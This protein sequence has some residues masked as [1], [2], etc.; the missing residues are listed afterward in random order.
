M[1]E[2]LSPQV[3]TVLYVTLMILLAVTLPW[4]VVGFWNALIGLLLCQLS[5]EP[6]AAVL[7]REMDIS[8]TEPLTSST[9]VLLC[10][11]NETP[12]RI[13]RNLETM[14]Q[15]LAQPGIGEHFHLYILSDTSDRV[16]GAQ[17]QSCFEAM[18]QRWSSRIAITYRCRTDN[19]GYKAGNIAD[20]CKHWGNQH[21]FALTLDVDSFM[22]SGSMLRLVR[23]MQASPR[24]GILQ[25]L[26]VGLPS[27][28]AF[29]RL[30]QYG[31]RLSMRSYT[32]GSAWW[33]YDCGP[34][35]GHNAVIRLAPFIEHC[36]M[37]ILPTRDGSTRHILSHD[38]VEAVLMR[39]AGFEVRVFPQEDESWEENPTTLT[40]FIR[41]DLRWCEGNLQYIYLLTLPG[42][43]LMNRYQ[44]TLAIFMFL[45][46]PAWIAMLVLGTLALSL[47]TNAADFAQSTESIILLI[48]ALLMWYQPK[49]AGALDVLLRPEERARFGGGRRFAF[50]L[51]LE[52]FFSILMN[53]ISWLNQT[54]FITGLIF[55]KKAGWT[56]QARDD[57]TI[58]L[59][60]AIKQFWPHTLLGLILSGLLLFTHPAVLPYGLIFF[61]G[62]LLAI[63]LAVF[64]SQPWLGQWMIS[65]R[66]LSLPEEI[67]PPEA[68]IALLTPSERP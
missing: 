67:N 59:S 56:A 16:I 38:Q 45:G 10:I 55:G 26:V 27:T 37:P 35:W 3:P 8:D 52:M 58:A 36:D 17:E 18:Q 61:S 5:T 4:M 50:S 30:F 57:H 39:R 46:S 51:S 25:G 12:E 40:E 64:T 62:L 65:H 49:I 11:R 68:L 7:P 6:T 60:D 19:T 32:M 48:C 2:A 66:L 53:P 14:L 23:M 43:K 1:H 20:F 28:S 31:M 9:A 47:H 42:L 33:Q 34:Y 44:L 15:G 24:L 21:D 41:R 54:M 13:E 63:P 29:T 22:T